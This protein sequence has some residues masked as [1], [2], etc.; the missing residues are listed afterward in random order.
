MKI[1]QLMVTLILKDKEIELIHFSYNKV[2]NILIE[3]VDSNEMELKH[4]T[5]KIYRLKKGK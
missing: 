1:K 3:H 4:V 5:N 2:W